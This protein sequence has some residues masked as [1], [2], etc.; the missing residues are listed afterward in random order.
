MGQKESVIQLN[1]SHLKE[2]EIKYF[3]SFTNSELTFG[4]CKTIEIVNSKGTYSIEKDQCK[5]LSQYSITSE[6]MKS[7]WENYFQKYEFLS[8]KNQQ[9]KFN[10]S[11]SDAGKSII[12]S[13]KSIPF[14]KEVRFVSIS[15][16]LTKK[17][18]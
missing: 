6:D 5:T 11:G 13:V 9:K 18:I 17:I 1:E 16:N 2:I 7:L 12:V 15:S 10:T 14:R 4:N 8:M 3:E